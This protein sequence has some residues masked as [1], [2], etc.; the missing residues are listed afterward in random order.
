MLV[1]LSIFSIR[2]G[3]PGDPKESFVTTVDMRWP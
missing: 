1:I 2:Q 3:R